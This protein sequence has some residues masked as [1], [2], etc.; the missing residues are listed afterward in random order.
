MIQ[1]EM[2]FF[3]ASLSREAEGLGLAATSLR[4][5]HRR[6]SQLH[7]CNAHAMSEVRC[8]KVPALRLLLLS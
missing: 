8:F 6:P 2:K 7:A 1:E 4:D 3:T 5:T